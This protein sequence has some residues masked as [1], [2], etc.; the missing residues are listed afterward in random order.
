VFDGAAAPAT[1][2]CVIVDSRLRAD[3]LSMGVKVAA[4]AAAL[5]D[6]PSGAIVT[7]EISELAFMSTDEAADPSELAAAAGAAFAVVDEAE[8][9]SVE[10]TS[11]FP[12]LSIDEGEEMRTE[13]AAAPSPEF[14]SGV[15][16][17]TEPPS[18]EDEAALTSMFTV[19]VARAIEFA[20]AAASPVLSGAEEAAAIDADGCDPASGT[21]ETT[22]IDADG[23]EPASVDAATLPLS[24]EVA[25]GAVPISEDGEAAML[26]AAAALPV[27]FASTEE[28]AATLS[29]EAGAGTSTEEAIATLVATG[30]ATTEAITEATTELAGVAGAEVTCGSAETEFCTATAD[31]VQGGSA[32][33][34]PLPLSWLRPFPRFARSCDISPGR[35]S[36][37]ASRLGG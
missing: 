27:L 37:G 15:A 14:A 9:K 16:D 36:R 30:E 35:N 20:A 13:V 34:D 17:A 19:E 10:D 12:L 5:L 7:V 29:V 33:A 6:E 31:D 2:A 21:E 22:A 25:A 28:A 11:P 18:V 24:D 26:D 4:A 32:L 1:V 8:L 3:E 23:C